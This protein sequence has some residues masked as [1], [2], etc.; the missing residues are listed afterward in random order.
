MKKVYTNWC[1]HTTSAL[2]A[3]ATMW[4]S[5]QR[6]VPK[7]VYSVS[8][9]LLKNILVWRNVLYFLDG[10]RSLEVMAIAFIIHTSGKDVH[11][12]NL[13]VEHWPPIS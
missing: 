4:N 11:I 8:I 1:K 3:K 5:S 6:Y 9:L 10:P 7:L 13:V 2:M 12:V